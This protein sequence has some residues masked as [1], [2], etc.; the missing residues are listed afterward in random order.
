MPVVTATRRGGCR[1][2]IRT[3]A[4]S[5]EHYQPHW[6]RP[7]PG[8]KVVLSRTRGASWFARML[9]WSSEPR[10][11][12]PISCSRSPRALEDVAWGFVELTSEFSRILWKTKPRQS[13]FLGRR[14]F[15]KTER[16]KPEDCP[17]TFRS[18]SRGRSGSEIYRL[19]GF[20]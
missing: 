7:L 9:K 13:R 5:P 17:R 20:G 12:T 11:V 10:G 16:A 19:C 4:L 3:R 1:I 6:R 15:Q 2:L 14:T 8:G 18:S